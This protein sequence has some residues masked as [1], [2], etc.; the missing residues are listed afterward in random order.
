MSNSSNASNSRMQQT[1]KSKHRNGVQGNY[2]SGKRCNKEKR[3]EERCNVEKMQWTEVQH[4]HC[5]Y[6]DVFYV[7]S[8]RMVWPQCNVPNTQF[9]TQPLLNLTHSW[10]LNCQQITFLLRVHIASL[11]LQTRII[12]E[13]I[14]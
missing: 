6:G 3:I 2:R 13:G 14:S 7:L 1:N 12:R 8:L 10:V 5:R 4:A 11:S 9:W